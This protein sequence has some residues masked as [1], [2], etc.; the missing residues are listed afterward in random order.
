[1]I[2]FLFFSLPS[3]SSLFSF[4]LHSGSFSI[5]VLSPKNLVYHFF[6]SF[7]KKNKHIFRPIPLF[8]NRAE[9]QELVESDLLPE[10]LGIRDLRPNCRCRRGRVRPRQGREQ[11]GEDW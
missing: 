9:R 3:S 8:P 5:S 6:D 11:R 7:F 2:I 10:P 4:L 1:M